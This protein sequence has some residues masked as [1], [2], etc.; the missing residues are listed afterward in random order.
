MSKIIVQVFIWIL[1]ANHFFGLSSYT[2]N[3]NFTFTTFEISEIDLDILDKEQKS[4]SIKY[5]HFLSFNS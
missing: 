3:N 4:N 1:L 2:M 5:K